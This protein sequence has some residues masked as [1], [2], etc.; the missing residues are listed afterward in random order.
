MR[1][2]GFTLILCLLAQAGISQHA[3]NTL[4]L[5]VAGNER[6]SVV[7][8][9]VRLAEWHEKAFWPLYESYL[10]DATKIYSQTY[11]SLKDLAETDESVRQEDAFDNGWK[12]LTYRNQDLALK[13]KYYQEVAAVL[14]GVVALQ[15][16][17]TETMMDMLES[18][19]VYGKSP[20]RNFRFHAQTLPEAEVR[21]AKH[22]TM[23]AALAIPVDKNLAFWNVYSRYEEECDALLGDTYNVY[24]LFA[25]DAAD[26]TP[27]L[28][29]RLGY[30][31]LQV[32]DREVKLKERYFLEMNAAVGSSLAAGFLAWEDYYSIIS[33]MYAWADTP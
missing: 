27:A 31:L 21:E 23:A 22:N 24:S 15:F 32:M 30:D 12:L 9:S 18:A 5:T 8:S 26:F 10:G 3:K 20:W 17:Q 1:C 13:K 14:N 19:Q 25:S 7:K 29:K 6:M 16:L 2:T 4:A 11:R 33:K 28:A